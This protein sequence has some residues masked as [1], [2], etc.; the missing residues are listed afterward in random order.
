MFSSFSSVSATRKIQGK[1]KIDCQQI[2][3]T[4]T[5]GELSEQV[6]V[7]VEE[8]AIVELTKLEEAIGGDCDL[9]EFGAPTKTFA[10]D[11]LPFTSGTQP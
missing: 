3:P 1:K 2:V 7:T 4:K 5:R 9:H 10:N 11:V 6:A 8:E